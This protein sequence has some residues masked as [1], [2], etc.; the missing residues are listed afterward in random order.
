MISENSFEAPL[1]IVGVIFLAT[2]VPAFFK[3]RAVSGWPTALGWLY[4]AVVS[5][6]CFV[7]FQKE[8]SA[9]ELAETE[10]RRFSSILERIDFQQRVIDNGDITLLI[11]I[12]CPENLVRCEDAAPEFILSK[13]TGGQLL[14]E[15]ALERIETTQPQSRGLPSRVTT[16]IGQPFFYTNRE[17]LLSIDDLEGH[18]LRLLINRVPEGFRISNAS[19]LTK[20]HHVRG[21][22]SVEVIG[23]RER[24][25]VTFR[26]ECLYCG[27]DENADD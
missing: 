22:T 17:G 24:P 16:Y 20:G 11:N 18:S 3:V 27:I 5:G 6:S 19:L 7:A 25:A 23:G 2:I 15:G 8:K 21:V 9:S 4:L 13:P 10:L 12:S 1:F 14:I 26:F